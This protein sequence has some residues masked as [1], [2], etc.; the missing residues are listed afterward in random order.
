M[1]KTVVIAGTLDTKG[2]DFAFVRDLI[3]AEGLETLV[4]D[5]GVMQAPAFAPDISRE[6]VAAAAGGDLAYLASGEHKD[7]AMQTMATGLAVVVRKLF[8][9][10]KLDGIIGM[11]GGGNTSIA[12]A[13]MRTLPVGVP[14]LM[15]STFGGTDVSAWAGTKDIT[16]MPSV[17]DVSGLNSISRAFTPTLRGAICG[18]V[19]MAAPPQAVE[20]PLITASMFGNTT[21]C[22]NRARQ[23]LKWR[24]ITRCWSSTPMGRGARRWRG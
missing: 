12:T 5:F 15:L 8:E 6:E 21:T 19:K 22:V 23:P 9:Q 13:A 2:Q 10:G 16:F 11:G 4:V 18:M 14:K 1:P 3:E 20:K 17:V 24:A 7:E